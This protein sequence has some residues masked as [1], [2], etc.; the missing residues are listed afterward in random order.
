MAAYGGSFESVRSIE[1][2]KESKR[3]AREELL[4]QAKED[5]EKEERRKEQRRLRGEDTWMLSDVTDRLEQIEQ[6]QDPTDESRRKGSQAGRSIQVAG[7][8]LLP[9]PVR[10]PLE[11]VTVVLAGLHVSDVDSREQSPEDS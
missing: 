4:A 2:K 7:G 11:D 9:R 1:E 6:G 10:K 8:G 5:Y 3:R